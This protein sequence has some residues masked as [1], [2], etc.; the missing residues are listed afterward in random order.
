MYACSSEPESVFSS[1]CADKGIGH[2]LFATHPH[3]AIRGWFNI[4]A[5]CPV[6]LV[7]VNLYSPLQYLVLA[8]SRKAGQLAILL[9]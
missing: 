8:I 9:A 3:P 7:A 6:V 5:A 4:T 2:S 1:G